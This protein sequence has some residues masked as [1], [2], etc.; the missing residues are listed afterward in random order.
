MSRYLMIAAISTAAFATTA[1]A[2]DSDVPTG[3]VYAVARIGVGVDSDLRFKAADL[4]PPTTF[5]RN[6]DGKIGWA[7]E[8]GAGYKMENIRV[9]GTIG[10]ASN[11]LDRKGTQKANSFDAGGRVSKLDVLL[12]A[13]Y[14][15]SPGSA[16]TP[17]IGGGIGAARITSKLQRTAGLP[18]GGTR[19]NDSAWGFA[20]HATAGVAFNISDTVTADVGV[21]HERVSRIRLD[22]LVGTTN[23]ARK[24][25]TSYNTTVAMV[26]F[27]F[28]F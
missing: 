27:R 7:G 20:Y 23:T 6:A 8:V 24:F 19:L 12:S 4:A 13:Y 11:N 28:G 14:D 17:Y 25:N 18:V 9:E 2:Q 1:S 15:F 26:G 22:G 21:R 10:Y 16:F 3:G 5:T